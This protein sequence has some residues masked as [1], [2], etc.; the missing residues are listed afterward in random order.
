[1]FA[2]PLQ[3]PD[4][5]EEFVLVKAAGDTLLDKLNLVRVGLRLGL[6]PVSAIPF[7]LRARNR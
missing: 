2:R 4:Q 1:M 7:P 3:A 6:L 5:T